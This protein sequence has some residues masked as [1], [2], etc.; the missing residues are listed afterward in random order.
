MRVR[1]QGGATPSERALE[2][3]FRRL[4]PLRIVRMNL[5]LCTITQLNLRMG[6]LCAYVKRCKLD[7]YLLWATCPPLSPPLS[8]TTG[9]THCVHAVLHG[10]PP[11]PS[12]YQPSPPCCPRP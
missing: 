11:P 8:T 10:T 2:R 12:V 1:R 7:F 9:I 5:P 6:P 4:I 3:R